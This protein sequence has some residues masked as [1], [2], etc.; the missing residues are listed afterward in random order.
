[1]AAS[2][3]GSVDLDGEADLDL[4]STLEKFDAESFLA[5]DPIGS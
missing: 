4:I 5:E 2:R 3:I 1:M